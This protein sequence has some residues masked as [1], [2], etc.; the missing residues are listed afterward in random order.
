MR[1]VWILAMAAGIL[2]AVPSS[3]VR[4][5][6]APKPEDAVRG[7]LSAFQKGEYAEAYAFV[8]KAMSRGQNREEW[9]KDQAALI[10]RSEAQILDFTIFPGKTEGEKATVPNLLKSKDKLFNQTG[11][12]EYELYIL[13]QEDGGWK[14]DHQKL[15]MDPAGVAEWFPP[16]VAAGATE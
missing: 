5:E 6:D 7:Y 13:V 4:A 11:A 8:S 15:L 3:E 1:R 12:L 14:I 10:A 2:A 16:D 9:A